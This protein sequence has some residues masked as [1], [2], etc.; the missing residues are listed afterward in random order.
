M[1]LGDTRRD[2]VSALGQTPRWRSNEAIGPRDDDY[3]EIGAPV[4]IAAPGRPDAL[5]YPHLS[6]MLDSGRVTVIMTA[7][8][9]AQTNAGVAIG[10]SLGEARSAYP[11]LTCGNRPLGEGGSFPYCGGRLA[12]NR[13]IWFGEDPIASITLASLELG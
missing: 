9:G 7:E 10:D 6:V 2:A 3:Y 5:R 1:S 12:P 13:W 4:S 11:G 8:K